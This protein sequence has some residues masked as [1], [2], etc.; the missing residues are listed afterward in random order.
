MGLSGKVASHCGPFV[1]PEGSGV[2]D[3]INPDEFTLHCIIVDQ[4]IGVVSQF[5]RGVVMAKFDVK[6]AYCNVPVHPL[7]CYLLDLKWHNQYYVDLA[8]PFCLCSTRCI[9]NSW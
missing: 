4:V 1:S 5:S 2:I 3:E 6:S 7:D 8:L 9:F